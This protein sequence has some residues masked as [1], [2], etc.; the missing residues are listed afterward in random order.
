MQS[1]AQGFL[2][3]ELT[4]SPAY[5]GYVGFAS[6]I[7]SWLF[8]LVGGVV[9][10]RMSRRK[11]LTLT[12]SY[13]MLLAF[14]LSALSFA[15]LVRP[16]HILV[17][18]AALGVGNAFDAPTRLA[19]V[20]ELVDRRHLANAIALNGT[21]FTLAL[22]TGPTLAGL[23]YAWFGPSWC[24]L[25]NGVS[26]LA[27][28]CALQTMK[29]GAVPTRPPRRAG[30][31]EVREGL[32]FVAGSRT[33]RTLILSIGVGSTCV[34]AFATLLP[35]WAVNVLGGDATTNGLLQSARGLGALTGALTVA[36]LGTRP[37][38]GKMFASGMI[39]G[40]TLLL[41]FAFVRQVPLSLLTVAGVGWG[42]VLTFNLANALVQT[43]VPDGLRGRVM[44]VYSLVFFGA[45][46]IGSLLFGWVAEAAG[47]P[48]AL[49]LGAAVALAFGVTAWFRAPHVRA[50]E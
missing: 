36:S 14:V 47:E 3:Y 25:I 28:I 49:L 30:L 46:T 38:K 43:L 42:M 12:Q 4:R 1:T 35:A 5:L 45:F 13:M 7:T 21:M 20:P 27:V 11:L 10:D 40:P 33:I 50:L 8:M 9:A 37:I 18:A 16:W 31:E 39:L 41:L 23:V 44:S 6:G 32:R 29:F 22:V 15:G 34:L 19:F 2:V 26:F 24:F 17:L 48:L